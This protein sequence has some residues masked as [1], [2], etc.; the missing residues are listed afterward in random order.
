MGAILDRAGRYDDAFAAYKAA[1]DLVLSVRQAEKLLWEAAGAEQHFAWAARTFTPDLFTAAKDLGN[2]SDV[3]VFVVGMPRSGTTLVEQILASHPRVHGAGELRLLPELL[4]KLDGGP[5]HK[6]PLQ[7]DT[8]DTKHLAQDHIERLTAFDPDAARVVD[9]LPDN[10]LALGHIA[11]L[12]PNA[13]VIICRRDPRDSCLSSYFQYFGDANAWSYDLDTCAA[14]ARQIDNLAELWL[15]T[16]PLSITEVI[17]ENLVDNLESESRRLIDFL[18]LEWEPVCLDF[19]Q[20]DRVVLTAS[21][22]QVR[23]PLYKT[24]VGRWQNYRRHIGPLLVALGLPNERTDNTG[25]GDKSPP[26]EPHYAGLAGF[27]RALLQAN[28]SD[29]GMEASRRVIEV[30][31][32]DPAGHV[33]LGIALMQLNRPHDAI[34]PLREAVRLAPRSVEARTNLASALSLSGDLP[35]AAQAWRDALELRPDEVTYLVALGIILIDDKLAH[36]AI[37]PLRQAIAIQPENPET[38][39]ALSLALLNDQRAAEA[40]IPARAALAIRPASSKYL[41]TLGEILTALGRFEDAAS[42][43]RTALAHDPSATRAHFGLSQIGMALEL[44]QDIPRLRQMLVDPA[45]SIFDRIDAGF[46]L[47]RLL[48]STKDYDAAFE[49]CEAASKLVIQ[50]RADKGKRFDPEEL[51]GDVNQLIA[52]FTPGKLANTRTW[53]NASELPVFIVGMPRS[54]TTL[55]EQIV[56]RHPRVFGRGETKDI[57][58][59][60]QRLNA[61][62]EQSGTAFWTAREIRA[63]AESL[64]QRMQAA[65]GDALRVVDKMPDNLL[66]LGHIAMLFPR[67]R[68]IFCRRDLR[69]VGVSCF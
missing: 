8:E 10:I 32:Q 40:E 63:T 18:G 14:R 23:Q 4:A 48:Q 34:A 6:S 16:L 46:A 54:G 62:A 52:L 36:D 44:I 19:H 37:E 31:P 67:A 17:Y 56:A 27:A 7:W 35:E 11:L 66:N 58:G 2:P 22:W 39:H 47:S 69:D 41:I 3:P 53:G 49:C 65:G 5:A 38:H 60:I 21:H 30:R 29:R 9:K 43:F 57:L 28:R 15:S 51:R 24:S 13:K 26:A 42:A 68:I 12:F 1:N 50:H 61:A 55:T 45:E 33:L 64:L 25:S 20:H 59:A